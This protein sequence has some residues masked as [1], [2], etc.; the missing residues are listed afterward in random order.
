MPIET[1][2]QREKRTKKKKR[3]EYPKLWNSNKSC[4]TC[5]MVISEGEKK[6]EEKKYLKQ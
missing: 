5:V 6:K 3:T 4:I 1:E 2:K